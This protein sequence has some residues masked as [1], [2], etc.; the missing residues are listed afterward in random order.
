MSRLVHSVMIAFSVSV[1]FL[2]TVGCGGSGNTVIED[3]RPA[4]EVQQQL[5]D[6]DKQLEADAASAVKQ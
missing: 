5:E 1:V 2:S 3:T 4:A 6:Y